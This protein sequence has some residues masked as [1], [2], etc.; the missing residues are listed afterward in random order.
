[1]STRGKKRKPT[2]KGPWLT[3]GQVKDYLGLGTVKAIYEATRAGKLV[4]YRW[5]RRLLYRQEEIDEI[6]SQ[7][8]DEPAQYVRNPPNDTAA[9]SDAASIGS[10]IDAR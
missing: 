7:G 6:I 5:G 4:S 8:R 1:M 3:A 10:D 2:K 9:E